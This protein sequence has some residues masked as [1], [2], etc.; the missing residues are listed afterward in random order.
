MNAQPT[1]LPL[2]VSWLRA[3]DFS[4][5]A[6]DDNAQA[7]NALKAL[8]KASDIPLFLH[9]A[10]GCGKTHLL[11][12]AVR[13]A[14]EH[15]RRSAYLPL[16]CDAEALPGYEAFDFVCIDECER[17][18]EDRTLALA[19]VRLMD[20]LSSSAH[21]FVVASRCGLDAL[22][23]HAPVDLCTR[24]AACNVY[25][26]K[27]L[28]DAGLRDALQRQA[29]ARGLKLGAP[30]A[31]YLVHHLPRDI[32]ILVTVLNALDRL[33]L[34]AGRRV[35]IPLVQQWLASPDAV[36]VPT[37]ARTTTG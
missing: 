19:M 10:S 16:S 1:Q 18:T 34:S 22:H 15:G 32:A 31:D 24:L 21:S 7:V 28:S 13:H 5:Y 11:Q 37:S 36:R 12:A 6:P 2:A 30:I 17:V 27:P 20:G 33:S 26:L 8:T 35:T 14:H 3:P 4:A 23:G 29:H 9:G 25:A